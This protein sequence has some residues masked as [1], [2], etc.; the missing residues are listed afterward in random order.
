MSAGW[1]DGLFVPADERLLHLR[2]LIQLIRHDSDT[3]RSLAFLENKERKTPPIDV[4]DVRT[5]L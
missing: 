1:P 3:A 5:I 2:G 4:G